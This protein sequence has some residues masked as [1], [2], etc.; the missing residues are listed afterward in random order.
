MQIFGVSH[1]TREEAERIVDWIRSGQL[2]PVLHTAFIL[3]ELREAERYFVERDADFVGK[4]VIVPDRLWDAHGARYALS[5]A[6]A[7][8]V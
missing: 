4:V 3:S 6:T 8:S 7:H 1:G 2:K 5:R